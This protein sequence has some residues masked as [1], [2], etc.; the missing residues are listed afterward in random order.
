VADT[1]F[2]PAARVQLP[3]VATPLALVVVLAPV[4]LPTPG[5]VAKV[6]GIPL[7]PLPHSSRTSTL[8]AV[9]TAEPGAATVPFPALAR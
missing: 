5:T 7:T 9:A 6:T 3:S 2:G 4:T 1:T 8:G